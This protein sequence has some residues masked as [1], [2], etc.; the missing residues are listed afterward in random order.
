MPGRSGTQAVGGRVTKGPV[1]SKWALIGLAAGVGVGYFYAARLG[2][3]LLTT[4]G[5]AVFWPAAGLAAGTMIALG[6]RSRVPVAL[7]VMAATIVANL[8]GDRNLAAAITFAVCNA[9]E[10]AAIAWLIERFLGANFNLD[11]FRRVLGF[12]LAAALATAL[13]GVG[14]ALGFALFHSS[15]APIWNTWFNWFA[16]DAMGVATVA[17]LTIGVIRSLRDPPTWPELVEGSS[18]LAVLSTSS[19]IGFFSPPPVSRRIG[20]RNGGHSRSHPVRT[21]RKG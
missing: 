15:Q 16:S 3:A 6:P 5:V 1:W 11:S 14:G 4:D 10:A 18:M 7:G 19:A 8:M 12:F 9:G 17:P 21:S 13:S 20:V 2:L